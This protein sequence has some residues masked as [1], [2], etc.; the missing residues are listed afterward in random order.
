[1]GEEGGVPSVVVVT[2][3][4]LELAR[5]TGQNLGVE[6]YE[7]VVVPHPIFSRDQVWIDRQ[8]TAVADQVIS[9]LSSAK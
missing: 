2:V 7:P 4:F 1:M 8:A 6:G 9:Q 5:R 3:P